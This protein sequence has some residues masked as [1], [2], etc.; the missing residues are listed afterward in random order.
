MNKA[1]R[2]LNRKTA[3]LLSEMNHICENCCERGSHWVSTRGL[4]ILS[5]LSGVDDQEGF[6]TCPK[7][8]DK[9][10]RRIGGVSWV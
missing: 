4:S 8:Y 6:W 7:L 10:G 9:D 2:N 3:Y 1:Q 5:I